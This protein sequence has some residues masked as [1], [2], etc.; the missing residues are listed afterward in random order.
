MENSE[1]KVE[2]APARRG[3][4]RRNWPWFVPL[5]VLGLLILGVVGGAAAYLLHVGTIKSLEP[6]QMALAQVRGDEEVRRRLGQPIDDARWR[7]SARKEIRGNR[8]DAT[9]DFDVSGPKG[10]A[11]V[12]A[13]ARLI[14]GVWGLTMVDVAF[15]DGQRKT[16]DLGSQGGVA[17]APKWISPA[18]EEP[19]AKSPEAPPEI[20]LEMPEGVPGP[21]GDISVP[22]PE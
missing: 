19:A 21:P 22:L 20:E 1:H 5:G 13:Q 7:V 17:E 18:G 6:Y 15:S 9:L 2:E 8:G 12:R 3:W 16:L 11:H 4:L 14:N 10:K